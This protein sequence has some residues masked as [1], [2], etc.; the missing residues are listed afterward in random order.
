MACNEVIMDIRDELDSFLARHCGEN[1]KVTR[2]LKDA[3]LS[4]L[5]TT[6]HVQFEWEAEQ[7][8]CKL[9][10]NLEVERDRALDCKEKFTRRQG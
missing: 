4:Y 8:Q 1:D 10:N 3:M 6:D 9:E 5:E 2:A 7:Q